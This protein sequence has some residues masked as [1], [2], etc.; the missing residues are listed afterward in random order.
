MNNKKRIILVLSFMIITFMLPVN[1]PKAMLI[2]NSNLDN[3]EEKDCETLMNSNDREI[4]K[5]LRVDA[6]C[7]LALDRKTHEILF[8]QNGFEIVPM[9]STTKILTALVGINS[10]K[11]EEKF[12]ISKNA[13]S[14]RGSKVGYKAGEEIL[15]K[16]LLV[17][18]MFKSG[19]DA[20]IA[21]AEGL[22]GSIEGFNNIMN[23]YA[24]SIGIIDSHFET[25]HGLDSQKH[26]TTAYDLAIVTAVAMEN[27]LFRDIVGSK[28]MPKDSEG[29][30]RDYNN[31]NKILWK[32][33]GANGVKTGYTGQAGKC[34]VSSINHNDDDTIIVVL[35]CT[36]R[37]NQ[38]QKIYDYI[39]DNQAIS[40]FE[41]SPS[42]LG[43]VFKEEEFK[44][45]YVEKTNKEVGI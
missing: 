22:G 25:P 26:Y 36:D 15:L 7:A 33:E 18:L 32:I 30:T 4:F 34:L 38:T 35:N 29:F 20:A 39:L 3:P 2:K 40:E 1:S 23:D 37:W 16:E 6:R 19:N 28:A 41:I 12:T 8:E 11:L 31:I 13:A 43:E 9:A 27:Q 14:I 44:Y 45:G 17:G 21:I 24:R 42:T 5:K 10:G